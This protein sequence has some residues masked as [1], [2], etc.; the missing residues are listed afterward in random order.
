MYR[1]CM[2]T[3]IKRLLKLII[4]ILY[5]KKIIDIKSLVD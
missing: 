1:S 4:D 2:T 5:A 3:N